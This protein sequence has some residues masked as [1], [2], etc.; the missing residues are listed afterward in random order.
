M[1]DEVAGFTGTI[2]DQY[3]RGLGPVIFVDYAQEMARRAVEHGPRR[4]LEIAAG[5][6]IVARR[7]R[8]L[9]PA[10]AHLTVTDLNPPMLDIARTKFKEGEKVAFQA[11]DATD[12]PFPDGSFDTAVCQFGL[13][14][15][16]DQATSFR[17]VHRALVADGRYLFSVWDSHRH[18]PFLRIAHEV[19]GRYFPTDPPQ[20]YRVPSRCHELDP[21]KAILEETGFADISIAVIKLEKEVHDLSAFARALI[22][23][24]PTID[25]IRARGDV[26]PD[27]IVGAL[28]IALREAFGMEPTRMPLQAIMFSARKC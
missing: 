16:P 26:A 13:M 3:D 12:L 1:S 6:G 15:F 9:L 8:D 18:N 21:L 5:T 28:T 17:E 19:V 23:G 24:N 27:Q 20:F 10:D 2:P 14:F 11:A 22:H 25:Q 7:L 4:V